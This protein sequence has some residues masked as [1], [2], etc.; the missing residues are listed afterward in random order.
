MSSATTAFKTT[1]HSMNNNLPYKQTI[2]SSKK[3]N[4]S[5]QII[6]SITKN[7]H[8]KHHCDPLAMTSTQNNAATKHQILLNFNSRATNSKI[9]TRKG[10]KGRSEEK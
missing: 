5:K 8:Q 3:T 7:A 1:T 10:G 6:S 2:Q 4:Q 9:R